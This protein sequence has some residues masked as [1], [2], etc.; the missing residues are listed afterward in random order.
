MITSDD[1]LRLA[2]RIERLERTDTHGWHPADEMDF[3]NALPTGRAQRK[4]PSS[5]I[6][7]ERAA[8]RRASESVPSEPAPGFDRWLFECWIRLALDL[9]S[10]AHRND[11]RNP[12]RMIRDMMRGR[13]PGFGG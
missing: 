7:R 4:L 11:P 5:S 9:E 3:R 13:F 8:K 12:Q 2:L 1:I 6:L 10:L